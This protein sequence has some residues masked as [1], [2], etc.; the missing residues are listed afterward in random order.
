MILTID[1]QNR[2]D[3]LMKQVK[4]TEEQLDKMKAELRKLIYKIEQK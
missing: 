1:E 4:R 2:V 3:L